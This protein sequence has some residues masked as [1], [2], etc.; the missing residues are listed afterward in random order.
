MKQYTIIWTDAAK[1]DFDSIIDYYFDRAG[2]RVAQDIYSRM[3]TQIATLKELPKRCKPGLVEGTKELILS[4]LPY[5]VVVEI[6]EDAVIVLGI[7]HTA[8]KYP[9][10]GSL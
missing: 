10:D 2:L 7:V 3:K 5:K 8:R 6:A 1:N 9:I 4:R